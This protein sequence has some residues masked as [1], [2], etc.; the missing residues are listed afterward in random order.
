MYFYVVHSNVLF[1]IL[2]VL[3]PKKNKITAT[4]KADLE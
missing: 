3:Q 4:A 2:F 1:P